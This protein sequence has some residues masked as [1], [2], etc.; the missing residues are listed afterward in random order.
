M[1]RMI[2]GSVLLAA[3][4]GLWSC[5]SDPTADLAGVPFKVVA[6]P[7]VVFIQQDSSQLIG[8]Q[9]VDELGGSIPETWT[10]TSTSP[11][12]TVA[13]DSGFRPVFNTDG[14]LTLPVAQTEVRATITGTALGVANFTATAGGKSIVIPVNVTPGNA[15][16]NPVFVPATPAPGD[17]VTMTVPSTFRLTPTSS[18]TF[19]GNL[20]PIIVDRAAD[21]TSLRFISAPTTD[22][23]ATVTLVQFFPNVPPSTFTSVARVTGSKV[24]LWTG[25]LPVTFS[26]L[27][28]SGPPITATLNSS[29]AYKTSVPASVFTF[30][31]Q[32]T[33]I[34]NSISADSLVANLSVG[35]NVTVPLTVTRITFKG[36]PQFEYTLSS[37]Q[38]ITSPVIANFPA[39]I[40]PT[41]PQVGDT[42]TITAGAG[43]TFVPT[44]T[45]TWPGASPAIVAGLTANTIRVLPRPGSAGAPTVVG[46]VAA[47]APAFTLSLP[48]VLP[49]GLT[50]LAT[51][52]YSGRGTPAT[53]TA[54]TIPPVGTDTLEFYDLVQNIDQFYQMNFATNA[55]LA[56]QLSWPA[57]PD[58]DMLWCTA[59]CAAFFG[60]FGAATGANPE[61]GTVAFTVAAPGPQF[62]LYVNLYAGAAPAWIRVRIIRTL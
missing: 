56:F 59:G 53:A 45:V 4:V 7:S 58:I 25:K 1:T 35:P 54:L 32:T 31:G 26:T 2:R 39:T 29:F 60:G 40:S 30:T 3:C 52:I 21:S 12:F 28:P 62:N 51:S 17:T 57:G 38:S 49:T 47:A 33:P 23:T 55:T 43:Y 18:V 6:L 61:V 37:L 41:N 14:T 9:L 16:F 42:V 44:A 19:P 22:T 15:K 8:F 20:A 48:A 50:M 27:T 5:S 11:N 36:A 10:I 34:L 46:V 24:G 13:I